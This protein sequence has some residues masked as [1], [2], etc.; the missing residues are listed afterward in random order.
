L[1]CSHRLTNPPFPHQ[2][3]SQKTL[4]GLTIPKSDFR[5]IRL[6]RPF[7]NV[8]RVRSALKSW[9][10]LPK[11][12]DNPGV[13]WWDRWLIAA[14]ILAIVIEGIFRP[15]MP[16]RPLGIAISIVFAVALWWRRTHPLRTTILTFGLVSVF[17]VASIVNPDWRW[18]VFSVIFVLLF[19]YNLMRWGTGREQIFGLAFIWLTYLLAI[20]EVEGL[21]EL[22]GGAVVLA[23]PSVIGAEVRAM[24]TRRTRRIEQVRLLERSQLARELHDTVAHH[25]SAIA[26]QAQ[27]GK[28]MAKTDTESA[29]EF[30]DIIESEASKTLQEMRTMVGA[31]REGDEPELTPGRGIA[32]LNHLATGPGDSPSVNIDIVGDLSDV[33]A[34]VES[35]LYRLA[36]ESVTNAVRHAREATRVDVRVADQGQEVELVVDDDGE[37]N[38]T[39]SDTGF[40]LIG[41]EERAKLLGGTFS[42]GPKPGRGWQVRALLPKDGAI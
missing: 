14:A 11:A 38:H 8:N 3:K 25:V 1:N 23:L 30:L 12:P 31:L 4:A 29:V 36:Q 32:D 17:N 40:G 20:P 22:I 42:S 24:H 19:P 13:A 18:E 9:W 5:P 26:I 2:A 33:Q 28:E 15:D 7:P 27:A 6:E 10:N 39:Q 37:P 35:T 16:W 34:S 41:M 21:D